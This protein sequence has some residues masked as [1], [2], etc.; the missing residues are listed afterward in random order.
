[1]HED[2]AMTTPKK[3]NVKVEV[4]ADQTGSNERKKASEK[5]LLHRLHQKMKKAKVKKNAAEKDEKKAMKQ[6]LD[7]EKKFEKANINKIKAEADVKK[8]TASKQIAIESFE[9]AKTDYHVLKDAPRSVPV[10]AEV[11]SKAAAEKPASTAKKA[12]RVKAV[13]VKKTST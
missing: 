5:K 6:L 1:V 12:V 7:A 13:R 9:A 11:A 8:R 10:Q 4:S 2:N 3:N